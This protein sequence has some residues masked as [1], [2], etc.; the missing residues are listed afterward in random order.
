MDKHMGKSGTN[1]IRDMSPCPS[2]SSSTTSS[3]T[4][5]SS[6]T[7]IYSSSSSSSSTRVLNL[8]LHVFL[9]PLFQNPN[10][11]GHLTIDSI[12]AFP[13]GSPGVVTA[14][15]RGLICAS[16]TKMS[17]KKMSLCLL[18]PGISLLLY[19]TYIPLTEKWLRSTE[20]PTKEQFQE[21]VG[22]YHVAYPRNYEFIID[23]P[24]ICEQQKPYVVAIVPVRPGD[25]DARN[26]IRKT[27][28]A[29]KVFGDKVVL[30]LFLIGLDSGNGEETLQEQ[31][32]NE[33]Q[34]YKDLLQSNFQ[35]SY[36]NLTI[37]T[38]VMMEWLSKKCQQASY[39][40]KVDADV[41]LNMNN[42][43]NMLVSLNTVQ[44]NY[45]TGLVWYDS[46]VIRDPS[47]RFF[48]PY[49]VYSRDIYPP[50][51]LGMCYIISIDLPQ[52]ILLESKGIKPIYIE[53]AYLGLCMEGLGI[54]PTNPPNM[55]LFVVR[56][57]Q[58]NRCYYSGL[59]AILTENTNQMTSYW[60]DIY[61]SSQPC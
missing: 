22:I 50:Y 16:F 59:I 3:T 28:G 19:L 43:I 33:S 53:D 55:E 30:V 35:D 41:L 24:D 2:P 52:K 11:L 37:K 56:L 21:E 61:S 14:V 1:F 46:H 45:M 38:M 48:L 60:T 27:W 4:S 17:L 5:S 49:D 15:N 44:Q 23:Q 12:D 58:Y 39:A 26:G 29:Q 31:L 13:S 51:P 18:V 34:Q 40:V 10:R 25:F 8:F 9:D 20:E 7:P 6:S 42:L 32:R 57:L 47:N 36:R 54:V